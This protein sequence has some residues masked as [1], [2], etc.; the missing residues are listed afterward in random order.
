MGEITGIN[1][2]KRLNEYKALVFDLDGTL[3][4]QR[5][6]RIKMAWMLGSYY[7]CHFWRLKEL[8]I[9]KRFR[10]T[11]ENWEEI[12]RGSSQDTAELEEGSLEQKQYA[13]VGRLMNCAPDRV[14]KV[15]ETW[16]YEKPLKTVYETRDE[17]LLG[18]INERREAGQSIFIFS[19]YPIE[20][21]LASLKLTVD[22]MYAATDERLSELKPSPKGLRL[23]MEDHSLEPGD[24]LMIGDRMSR[25]GQSAV[26]AGCDYAILP[27]SKGK[28]KKM[29][30]KWAE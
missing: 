26:N 10:E 12:C 19:D 21:K 6:L 17:A 15:I 5:Q 18:I 4:Y 20:D 7:R 8:F 24:I 2:N 3:Y 22:G 13:Y 1:M 25:D 29:Y 16:M 28:R 9:V 27:K 23:I 30:E 14:R 11:R